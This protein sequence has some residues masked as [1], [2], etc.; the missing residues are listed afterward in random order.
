[1]KKTDDESPDFHQPKVFFK[2]K[3]GAGSVFG[4][5][6]V[7]LSVEDLET[8]PWPRIAHENGI[9]TIVYTCVCVCVCVKYPR[10][11]TQSGF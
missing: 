6:G 4:M 9:N 1:M 5:R 11:L 8:A 7:V 3:A 10:T 2:A